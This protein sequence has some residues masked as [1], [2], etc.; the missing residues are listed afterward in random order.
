MKRL[1]GWGTDLMQIKRWMFWREGLTSKLIIVNGL[2]IGVVIWLVGISVK[3]FA[4]LVVAQNDLVGEGSSVSFNETMNAYLWK[5]ITM[6]TLLAAIIHYI[7]IRNVISPLKQ[8]TKSTQ[9]LMEGQYPDFV[10]PVS[11]DEIGRLTR[12]FNE[13]AKT[14]QQ[15][16]KKRKRLLSNLSHELR[17]PLSNLNGYLEA[18]SCGVLEGKRELFQSLL[19]ESQY[20]TRM[21]EQMHELTI[22]EGKK[23]II[24]FW[25]MSTFM[26]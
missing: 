7:F 11:D 14:L 5:A 6:A 12:N 19:E 1:E 15:N 4:C 10:P 25:N 26:I 18:L 20:L 3:D 23:I 2:V 13:L 17:T 16:E 24:W 8:L 22:W 21:V 9:R